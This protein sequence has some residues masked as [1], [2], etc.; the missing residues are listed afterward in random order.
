MLPSFKHLGGVILA[1]D[2][3]WTAVVQN[4]V[5]ARMVWRRMSRILIREGEIT[6][7][8]RFFFKTVI[9]SMLLLYAETRVVTPHMVLALGFFREQVERQL[10]GRLQ[11]RRLDGR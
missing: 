9:Q 11:R 4:I 7:V 3:D 10:T 6:W 1:A 2:D 8:S 5:K